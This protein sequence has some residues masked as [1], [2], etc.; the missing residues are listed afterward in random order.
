MFDNAM[1]RDMTE[2]NRH[3][4]LVEDNPADVALTREILDESGVSLQTAGDGVEALEHLHRCAET[5]GE[6]PSLVILDLNMPRMSGTE[7]LSNIRGD[8]RFGLLPV[9]VFSSSS[10]E[11]DVSESYRRGANSFVTKP[12]EYGAY[13]EA[14]KKLEEFWLSLARLPKSTI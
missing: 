13:E 5:E 3:V 1:F 11:G 8:A 4:L 9:V 14:V 12:I 7:F 2:H 6:L 10:S